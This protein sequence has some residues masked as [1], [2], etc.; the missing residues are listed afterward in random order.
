MA[1]IPIQRKAGRNIWPMLIGL[2]LLAAVLWFFLTQ[3]Q[4]TDSV[5]APADSTAVITNS[6]VRTDSAAGAMGTRSAIDSAAGAI[7]RDSAAANAPPAPR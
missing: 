7:A 3:R 6:G 4:S 2:L 1:E 5:V